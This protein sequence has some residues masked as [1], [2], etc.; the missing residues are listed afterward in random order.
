MCII[1]WQF[2]E[3]VQNKNYYKF[4]HNNR[5][6]TKT[7]TSS[8]PPSVLAGPPR[9]ASWTCEFKIRKLTSY[10]QI[11]ADTES[12]EGLVKW[13]VDSDGDVI[14][15]GKWLGSWESQ[16]FEAG[17]TVS[18]RVDTESNTIAIGIRDGVGVAFDV[19]HDVALRLRPAL[20]IF[21]EGDSVEIV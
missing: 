20:Y 2:E 18:V 12:R 14:D 16:E 9:N 4:E 21:M 19:P 10:F 15:S 3:T 8:F 7:T 11:G 6:L 1:E 13:S 17:R 5:L